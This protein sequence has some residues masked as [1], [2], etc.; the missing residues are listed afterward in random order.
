MS[1][2]KD[3]LP[4]NADVSLQNGGTITYANEV[5]AI[6][7]GVAANEVEGVT[8]MC[9]AGGI[10]EVVSKNRNATRGVKVEIGT[11]EVSVDLYCVLDYGKPIHKVAGEIQENV[12]K[13]VESMTGL[14]VV[15][16]DVHV[17]AISFDKEKKAS[18]NIE[19]APAKPVLTAA[20]P[21]P[22]AEP[23]KKEAPA[24]K[25]EAAAAPVQE[26]AAEEEAPV[27]AED[28]VMPEG[29]DQE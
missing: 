11:E 18:Q 4:V 2:K 17:Q 19:A 24:V 16:C 14:H 7:A 28:Q 27:P 13:A 1:P 26:A 15:R 21:A 8:G 3:N 12:R 25:E 6:I 9:S 23:A 29:G 10:G 22:K 5:V 20:K